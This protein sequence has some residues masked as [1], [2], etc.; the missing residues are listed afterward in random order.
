M[1]PMH[2][3]RRSNKYVWFLL[4]F[5]FLFHISF[6]TFVQF[7][8]HYKYIDLCSQRKPT[9]FIIII[10]SSALWIVNCV[11]RSSNLQSIAKTHEAKW[12]AFFAEQIIIIFF[13]F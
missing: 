13:L 4:F 2:A 12:I 10:S 8:I 7:S 5:F 1:Y 11:D 3:M 6:A 9:K